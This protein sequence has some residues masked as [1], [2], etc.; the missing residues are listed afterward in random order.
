VHRVERGD[1]PDDR[2]EQHHEGVE[3]AGEEAVGAER[4]GG[5]QGGEREREERGA[6]GAEQEQRHDEDHEREQRNH[7]PEVVPDD[8]PRRDP[9]LRRPE[10]ADGLALLRGQRRVDRGRERA[11]A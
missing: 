3:G 6:E 1:R 2:H 8:V 9:H 4:H 10:H 7:P 5:R 11:R